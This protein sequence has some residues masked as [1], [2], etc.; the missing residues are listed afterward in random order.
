MMMT[1]EWRK[2]RMRKTMAIL[3]LE[4]NDMTMNM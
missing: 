3:V 1:A 2:I 4:K